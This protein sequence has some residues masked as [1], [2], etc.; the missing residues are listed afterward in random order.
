MKHYLDKTI[1]NSFACVCTKDET[2]NI[3][4]TINSVPLRLIEELK[5]YQIIFSTNVTYTTTTEHS[6]DYENIIVYDITTE[7]LGY[8]NSLERIVIKITKNKMC[9]DFL[10]S[11]GIANVVFDKNEYTLEFVDIVPN[12]KNNKPNIIGNTTLF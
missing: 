9:I 4:I 2:K 5:Y 12:M 3:M 11:G 10:Y 7:F 8:N 6:L 1:D